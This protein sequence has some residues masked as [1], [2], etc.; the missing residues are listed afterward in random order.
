MKKNLVIALLAVISVLSLSYAFYQ[1]READK[2]EQMAL[3][4]E[5]KAIE[6][7]TI[8]E[9]ARDMANHQR[10]LAEEQRLIAEANLVEAI[11]QKQLSEAKQ[12]KK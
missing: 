10:M 3:E 12:S 6:M 8:V 7:Q 5:Q 1:K 11:R 4:S 9:Q 2:F